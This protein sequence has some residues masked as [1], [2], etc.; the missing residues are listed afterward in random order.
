[1]AE[2]DNSI[3]I[4]YQNIFVQ[5]LEIENSKSRYI[6]LIM[7]LIHLFLIKSIQEVKIAV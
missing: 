5:Y 7:I 1:M 6:E 2:N 4:K 3:F